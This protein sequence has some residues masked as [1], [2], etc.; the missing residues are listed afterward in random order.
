MPGP[1]FHMDGGSS[2]P[3]LDPPSELP[4]AHAA[5]KRYEEGVPL[6]PLVKPKTGQSASQDTQLK[7][8]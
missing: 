6:W 5:T 3:T 7:P 8:I 2:A 4:E 1:A